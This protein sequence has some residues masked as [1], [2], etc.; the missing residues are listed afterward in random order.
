[1][2][3]DLQN[4]ASQRNELKTIEIHAIEVIPVS[5]K[6]GLNSEVEQT[7]IQE[8]HRKAKDFLQKHNFDVLIWGLVKKQQ[9]GLPSLFWTT[10]AHEDAYHD[11]QSAGGDEKLPTIAVND[12]TTVLRAIILTRSQAF[13]EQEG[14]YV[15]D[16]I[17]PFIE[18]LQALV[19]NSGN[20][21]GWNAKALQDTQRI[22]AD[23]LVTFGVQKGQNEPLAN[24][25][26]LYRILLQS[27]TRQADPLQWALIQ[28]SLGN[29]LWRLG[30]R[31]SDT[32]RLE[33]SVSSLR[34]ALLE[35]TREKFP[36][37]WAKTQN[38]LGKVLTTLGERHSGTAR[39][40]EAVKAYNAALSVWNTSATPASWVSSVKENIERTQSEIANRQA[41]KT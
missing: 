15:S 17:R 9:Q 35:R 28:H 7:N 31:E 36:L 11:T 37:Y 27:I 1:M 32:A 22:L 34:Q 19:N 2:T 6:I 18:E 33:E 39:L 21:P 24:A 14:Q 16:K 20:K 4:F 3:S 25:I 8:G 10:L 26:E 23:S 38:N 12:L 5:F 13:S 40:E 41:P 30:E 29:A